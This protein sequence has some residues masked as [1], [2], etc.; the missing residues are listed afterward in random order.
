[1]LEPV[2]ALDREVAA[3]RRANPQFALTTRLVRMLPRG[4]VIAARFLGRRLLLGPRGVTR[5]A[6]GIDLA[7]DRSNIDF[8]AELIKR[9]GSWDRHISETC[10]SLLGERGV[11]YDVGA[12]SGYV[13]LEVA[14]RV[15]GARVV[16][17]EPQ[18]GLARNVAVSAALNGLDDVSVYAAMLGSSDGSGTIFLAPNSIHAS[19]VARHPGSRAIACPSASIDALVGSG[20]LPPPDVMKIDVEG[21]EMDVLAG[22]ERTIRSRRPAI[23]FEADENL[24]RFGH[25]RQALFERLVSYGDY[26]LFF[27]EPDARR[28]PI[29]R[30]PANPS[31]NLVAIAR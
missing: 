30:D 1:M 31:S 14:A 7:I 4:K 8:C 16:A 29:E 19:A 17:F 3:F 24:A 28:T 10:A 25:T 11:F 12:N 23:V 15:P 13:A 6:S 18:P 27:I 2:R 20:D 22:A 5:T 26:A 9:G 21:A